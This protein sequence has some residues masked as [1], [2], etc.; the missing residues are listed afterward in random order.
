MVFYI[1]LG[2]KSQIFESKFTC[3]SD[4][5][6]PD[7]CISVR[8]WIDG[9]QRCSDVQTN[10]SDFLSHIRN[11][12]IVLRKA[13]DSKIFQLEDAWINKYRKS[14]ND[15]E[16][17]E[18]VKENFELPIQYVES[19]EETEALLSAVKSLLAKWEV[20]KK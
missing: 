19:L 1:K 3:F 11:D 6:T 5:N 18:F 13:S 2:E 16:I 14:S 20:E 7:G 10:I 9:E 8:Y 15:S 17:D 12:I 4:E